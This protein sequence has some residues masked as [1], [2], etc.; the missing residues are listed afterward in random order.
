MEV[1]VYTCRELYRNPTSQRSYVKG[2]LRIGAD[3]VFPSGVDYLIPGRVALRTVRN[4]HFHLLIAV[5]E[6]YWSF[7]EHPFRIDADCIM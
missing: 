4:Q 6:P 2:S 3:R 7:F 5:S 1:G